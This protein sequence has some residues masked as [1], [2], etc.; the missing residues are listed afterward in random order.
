VCAQLDD[1]L[2]MGLELAK[3]MQHVMKH[4]E[5][6]PAMMSE[7]MD[8]LGVPAKDKAEVCLWFYNLSA[9]FVAYISETHAAAQTAISAL[10]QAQC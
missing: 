10:S 5:E 4:P 1:S 2:D 9:W 3:K 7:A 8:Q 6:L